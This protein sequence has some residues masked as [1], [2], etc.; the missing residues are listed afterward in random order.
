MADLAYSESEEWKM[1]RTVVLALLVTAAL[2]V[3]GGATLAATKVGDSGNDRLR[4][5]NKADKLVGKGGNDLLVG[6]GANDLLKGGGG[7][8]R[9][10]DAGNPS[11]VD[12]FNCGSG[13]DA[14]WANP[15]D[16]VSPSCET[17]NLT[18]PPDPPEPSKDLLPDLAMGPITRVQIFNAGTAPDTEK[19][20][21][22]NTTVGNVGAGKLEVLGE[23]PDAST[24]NMSTTQRIYD[25]AGGARDV[26][27]DATLFFTNG[28]DAHTHW[29]VGDLEDYTLWE[30]DAN[31]N[32]VGQ[33]P[34][35]PDAEKIGF[36]LYDNEDWGGT[37]A[38]IDPFYRQHVQDGTTPGPGPANSCASFQPDA[39][40]VTMG[41][42]R[43]WGESFN[44]ST[45]GQ[46]VDVTGL[47]D[48][49]YRLR[50]AVDQADWFLEEEEANNS[51]YVDVRIT[52]DVVE[53]LREGPS[54]Q[55]IGG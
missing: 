55:P 22:F 29:H 3:A 14:V 11:E 49:D 9:L 36:C 39:L 4:G 28:N 48:G 44:R 16:T 23:R 20:L 21:R 35:V 43:G 32:V 26:S 50:T 13:R 30:L 37:A 40:S 52:G 33:G 15:A 34:V 10:Y 2:L 25:S 18:K 38:G 51:T 54:A 31:G 46:Y 24:P 6:R 45:N 17:K 47:P 42:S 19:R 12:T 7:R 5:T 53:V 41:F 8:D 1:R 27:T